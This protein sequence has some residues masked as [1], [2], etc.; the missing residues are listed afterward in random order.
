MKLALAQ[1]EIVGSVKRNFEKMCSVVDDAAGRA[2]VVVFPE[3]S[4]TGYLGISLE[5][6][7]QLDAREIHACLETL[8]AL[9]RDRKVA[10]VTGQYF[11]RCGRWYNNAVFIDAG[12][13]LRASYDKCNLVDQDCYHV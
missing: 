6:L 9:C 12:G 7:D 5:S 2:D 1:I 4:L 10:V 8:Q 3:S 11:K 13:A